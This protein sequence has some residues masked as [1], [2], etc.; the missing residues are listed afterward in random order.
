MKGN[1]CVY[2]TGKKEI[3]WN[4]VRECSKT[5]EWFSEMYREGEDVTEQI[6]GENL[7]RVKGKVLKRERERK[8]V[9]GE[10][11]GEKI[12]TIWQETGKG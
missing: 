10:G 12:E 2:S 1:G 9:K 6:W 7:D 5:K 11:K 3:V 8:K 4:I